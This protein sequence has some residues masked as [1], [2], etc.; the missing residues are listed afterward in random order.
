[1]QE[2]VAKPDL[3]VARIAAGQHGVISIWQLH[4]AGLGRSAVTTRVSTGR[5]HRLQRGVYAVG[6]SQPPQEGL[7]L[8]A[9][10]ACGGLGKSGSVG[11]ETAGDC[12]V[13]PA[14]PDPTTPVLGY[15]NAAL[16]YRSAACLWGLLPSRSG[17]VDV[18]VPGSGGKGRREGI[19]LHRS[20][21]LLPA[22]VTLCRGFPVTTPGRTISDLRRVV[23]KNGRRGLVSPRELRRAIRQANFLGLRIDEEARRERSRSDLE[24][25]F[26][27]LCRRFDLPQPEVNVRVGRHLVD[28][29]WRRRKL[30]VET[31]GYAAHRGRTAF[32]DDR[33]RDLDLRARGFEVIRLA[34]KQ[35]NDEP[36]RVAGVV[37]AALRLRV[38]ADAA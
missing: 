13:T 19:R 15:W 26:Q 9:V 28:F 30:V 32:E 34:E 21:S 20:I 12:A 7:W 14:H 23:G 18:S 8:A 27:A 4:G 29:C 35:L 10:L 31:D 33:G 37:G 2:Q 16:S 11:A 6:H 1:M 5:L 25:D 17:P 38:G 3:E 22:S 24:L 36:R